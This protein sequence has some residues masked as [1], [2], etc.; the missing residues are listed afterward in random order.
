MKRRPREACTEYE[1]QSRKSQQ[2]SSNDWL[3]IR[4][5]FVSL[6]LIFRDFSQAVLHFNLA[7]LAGPDKPQSNVQLGIAIRM[8]SGRNRGSHSTTTSKPFATRN[9]TRSV[10]WV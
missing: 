8:I 5:A 2:A 6:A 7:I 9:A 1:G 4:P 3:H 10:I